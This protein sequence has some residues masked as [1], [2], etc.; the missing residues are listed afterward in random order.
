[1]SWPWQDGSPQMCPE[2]GEDVGSVPLETH[3]RQRHHL[4][5]FRGQLRSFNDT[6]AFLLQTLCTPPADPQAWQLLE[7][8]VR[9]H[10]GARAE[11]FLSA[12]VAAT[13]SRLESS[14]RGPALFAAAEAIGA[15][16]EGVGL[17]A[18]LAAVPEQTARLLALALVSRSSFPLPDRVYPSLCA[19]LQDRRLPLETQME[20][21]AALL[22]SSGNGRN[23]HEEEVLEAL[24]AGM[25]KVKAVRRLRRLE[26]LVGRRPVLASLCDRLEARIRM[27]CP[28]CALELRRAEM[29]DHLW[30]EHNL[31][32]DGQRVRDPWAVIEDRLADRR[33]L[34]NPEMLDRCRALAQQTDPENGSTRFHRLLLR[35]GAQDAETEQA[36]QA[37]AGDR[38]A[39]LCPACFAFI[40]V[41]RPVLPQAVNCWH[42]RLSA[43]GYCLELSEGVLL[44]HLEMVAPRGVLYRGEEP[45]HRLTVRGALW[46]Q[47][48]PFVL[49]ALV[50][51]LAWESG[52]LLPVL[53]LLAAALGVGMWTAERWRPRAPLSHRALDYA[54]ALM[55][56]HL[57]AKEF[58]LPDAEFLAGLALASVDRGTP[59]L[60]R[61]TLMAA[62]TRAEEAVLAQPNAAGPLAALR[63]LAIHDAVIEDKDPVSLVVAELIDCLGGRLPLAYGEALLNDW[64]TD[65]WTPGN[66]GRLRVLL[67]DAAFEAGFEVSSLLEIGQSYAALGAVLE[68]DRPS[69]LVLLRLLWSMRATRPWD[70]AGNAAT[71]FERAPEPDSEALLHRFPDLLLVQEDPAYAVAHVG[72]ADFAPLRVLICGR[73][74]ALQEVLFE[75]HPPVIEVIGPR[76]PP[77][78]Y[79]E[80][81]VGDEA[82]RFASDP[83]EPATRLERWCRF[84]FNDFL[85]QT[86]AVMGWQ[87]PDIGARLRARGAVPCPECCRAVLPRL[88]ALAKLLQD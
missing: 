81:R 13:L 31:V 18:F 43:R 72:E 38:K 70:R 29:I 3:L 49:F 4:Y 9:E 84:L 85:P 57:Y 2:C 66:L 14:K 44:S 88:G 46:L 68:V 87:S 20:A 24:T 19:L 32:L 1:M 56:P 67:C 37:E 21:V 16:P 26:Q 63:R 71:V 47:A 12:S 73:G 78:D 7:S 69:G 82:F 60:R 64:Q 23:V 42:G 36:L 17:V 80:L 79:G 6:L 8:I 39:S 59:L 86:A 52:P 54:W 55:A 48:G 58:S 25:G 65:W 27:R 45:G 28:R 74:V 51:A 53:L 5:Q 83:T 41:P 30:R 75:R 77:L 34:A 40:P 22:R 35:A 50:T 10:H 15:A 62:I 11:H 33:S 76:L 61:A